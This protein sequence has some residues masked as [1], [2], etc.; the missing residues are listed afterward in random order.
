VSNWHNYSWKHVAEPAAYIKP[1]FVEK[2]SFSDKV[3]WMA[4]LGGV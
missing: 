3:K 2:Q 1:V 4:W